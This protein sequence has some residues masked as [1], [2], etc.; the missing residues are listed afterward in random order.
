LRLRLSESNAALTDRIALHRAPQHRAASHNPSVRSSRPTTSPP[1]LRGEGRGE[2][3]RWPY[4]CQSIDVRAPFAR[5]ASGAIA[6]TRDGRA[7]ARSYR[8]AHGTPLGIALS[9]KSG[10]TMCDAAAQAICKRVCINDRRTDIDRR[11]SRTG[12]APTEKNSAPYA[13]EPPKTTAMCR[14]AARAACFGS[15]GPLCGGEGWTIRPAGGSAWM[16]IPFRRGRSPVEKPGR[17]SRTVW[18]VSPDSAKR[19]CP[20]LWLLSL[21][22]ARESDPASGRRSEARGRRASWR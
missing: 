14:A 15:S 19:G 11:P 10:N 16:P 20:S 17:P 3:P 9:K 2:G 1:P 22:Q 7:Q 6:T 4:R 18:A 13:G 8:K 5:T 21:G 12:C